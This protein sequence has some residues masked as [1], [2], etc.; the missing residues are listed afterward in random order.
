MTLANAAAVYETEW[1]TRKLV[2]LASVGLRSSVMKNSRRWKEV[3]DITYRC[4]NSIGSDKIP[5]DVLNFHAKLVRDDERIP[6]KIVDSTA[7]LP[8][9][10]VEIKCG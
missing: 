7:I 1:S 3:S 6:D 5:D 2:E 9:D 4:Q 10:R 8:I